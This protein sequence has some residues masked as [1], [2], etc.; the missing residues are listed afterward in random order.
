MKN[1]LF[2][3]LVSLATVCQTANARI[4]PVQHLIKRI[5]GVDQIHALQSTVPAVNDMSRG[6]AEPEIPE[7]AV[8]IKCTI[9]YNPADCTPNSISA[10][11]RTNG[12][13]ADLT[14]GEE[15]TTLTLMPGK[16][17]LMA[18]FLKN[19]PN[20]VHPL[21]GQ[22]NFIIVILEDVE[23]VEGTEVE[24][25]T[26]TS[27][28][29]LSFR[30]VNID[31]EPIALDHNR[32]LNK[33][34]WEM[35]TISEGNALDIVSHCNIWHKDYGIVW[36]MFRDLP[37]T[38]SV[39]KSDLG[40]YT[41]S[42]I[43]DIYVND[44]SD[45]YR[46]S[47][48][49]IV[50]GKNGRSSMIALWADGCKEQTV[51]NNPANF[52]TF[53]PEFVRSPLADEECKTYLTVWPKFG[54]E[55]EQSY[56]TSIRTC[57]TDDRLNK[58]DISIPWGGDDEFTNLIYAFDYSKSENDVDNLLTPYYI[59]Q[60]G[61]L[62][63]KYCSLLTENRFIGPDVRGNY[64]FP[65]AKGIE[66][67]ASTLQQT[68]GGNA[69]VCNFTYYE[70]NVPYSQFSQ[71]NTMHFYLGR[72]GESRSIDRFNSTVTLDID[73]ERIASTL[74]EVWDWESNC[75]GTGVPE[76]VFHYHLE[77][78]NVIVDGLQGSNITD[79][80]FD[81]SQD[82]CWPPELRMVNFKDNTGILKDRFDTA[83][84][85]NLCMYGGDFNMQG[86][87]ELRP[88]G[89]SMIYW[90]YDTTD[91]KVEYAPYG[92]DTFSE[93]EVTEK[94]EYFMFP[95][96][97]AFMGCN[98]SQVNQNSDTGWYDLRVTLTDK[99]GNQQTQ[100][101]SPAFKI[102][103]NVGITSPETDA[104]FSVNVV[105]NNIECPTGASIYNLCGKKVSN[106]NLTAGIYLV[107]YNGSTV[108]VSIR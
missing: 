83:A 9:E 33:D 87:D 26:A 22:E 82:D 51:T 67:N 44:T 30:P 65:G 28:N 102:N 77:N 3:L 93:L 72:A 19:N 64:L 108:K 63:P 25:D 78:N 56:F 49:Q 34:T 15:Y 24:F 106:K 105:G 92:T 74:F 43:L 48:C 100:L 20:P 80:H 32:L 6:G 90:R 61:V 39:E 35:E 57:V 62:C 97:G 37:L 73:N 94:P 101:I 12:A 88:N 75:T 16:Y 76:G 59:A 18:T 84:D 41:G 11:N 45:K 31:G 1:F 96:F 52:L 38:F 4:T 58:L 46:F 8:T 60:D 27:T 21:M 50:S 95:A 91:W 81:K 14:P 68:F 13:D 104:T 70:L 7:G 107:T 5:P 66:Y 99:A 42:D 86:L 36:N 89:F 85:A 79:V 10:Y 53:E 54:G 98:M 55:A 2:T 71:P 29:R 40:E 103:S 17:D 69:P 47:E 23:V